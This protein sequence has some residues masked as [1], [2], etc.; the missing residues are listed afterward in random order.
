MSPFYT[1][2]GRLGLFCQAIT[3]ADGLYVYT[4]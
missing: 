4:L 3:G 2:R 1:P